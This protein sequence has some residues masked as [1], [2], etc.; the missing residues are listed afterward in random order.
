MRGNRVTAQVARTTHYAVLGIAF[1]LAAVTLSIASPSRAATSAGFNAT[2]ATS[3]SG[4]TTY[5]RGNDRTGFT[6]DSGFN[7]TSVK[8]LHLAWRKSDT[9]PHGVFSQP[10]VSNGLVYWGSFDG[11]ERATDTSGHLMWQRNLGTTSPP[12][13]TDP[14]EA[15]IASTPTLTTDVPVDGA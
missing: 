2:T 15:G 8:N 10:V 13:C 1:I 5:L 4:W 11:R 9:A 12:A 3:S 6:S 7:P 14:S